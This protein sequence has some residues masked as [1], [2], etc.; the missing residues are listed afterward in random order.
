MRIPQELHSLRTGS[1]GNRDSGDWC[2]IKNLGMKTS[3]FFHQQIHHHPDGRNAN[4]NY[5]PKLNSGKHLNFPPQKIDLP[6]QTFPAVPL[7]KAKMKSLKC[8]WIKN[9]GVGTKPGAKRQKRKTRKCK[10]DLEI[11]KNN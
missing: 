8:E 3:S 11:P 2:K 6:S 5:H 10:N 7:N 1:L 4:F 9:S